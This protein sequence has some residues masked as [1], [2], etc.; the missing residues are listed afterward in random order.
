M[1][2]HDPAVPQRDRMLDTSRVA[3][4][5]SEHFRVSV[6]HCRVRHVS[7]R[8]GRRLRV[9]YQVLA[10]DRA[11]VRHVAANTYDARR[12]RKIPE[13]STYVPEIDAVCWTFPYDRRL[14]QLPAV[15]EPS[16]E[17]ADAVDS[18]WVRSRL[19]DYNPGVSAV[20]ACLDANGRVIGYA[21]AH[22]GDEGEQTLRT[23]NIVAQLAN[24]APNGPRVARAL[25]YAKPYR[26]LVI[27]PIDGHQIGRLTGTELLTALR[28][29]G[30]TLAALHALPLPSTETDVRTAA[31]DALGRLAHRADGIAQVRPDIA[32]TVADLLGELRSRW[33]AATAE[34]GLVHGDVN[35]TN[36]I[37]RDLDGSIV[38]IDL[39]RT[40]AGPAAADLGNFLALL[41]YF[42]SRQ[43][44][45]PGAERL[46]ADAFLSGYRRVRPLPDA[47]VVRV[48]ESAALAERAFRAVARLRTAALPLVPALLSEAKGL[49]R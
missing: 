11:G 7:Y 35:E 15:L 43:L 10:D 49:L 8:P 48:H 25:G 6:R 32:D 47:D 27:E 40:G 5:L 29:Y 38:L 41:R 16:A 31:R 42:R 21:R 14:D 39:E 2:V 9:V 34:F 19:V 36:A 24:R 30:R 33:P 17:L 46:R 22:A 37:R 23:Q 26:T 45:S 13:G 4:A 1:L 44:I 28:S 3:V 18:R 20:L 12:S